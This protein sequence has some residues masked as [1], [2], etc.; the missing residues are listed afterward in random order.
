MYILGLT[1]ELPETSVHM[2]EPDLSDMYTLVAFSLAVANTLI[3]YQYRPISVSVE[4][5][6]SCNTM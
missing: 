3:L 2:K 1:G 4:D 6:Y 5:H